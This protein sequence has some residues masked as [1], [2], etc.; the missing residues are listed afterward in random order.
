ME[1]TKSG[2]ASF[3]PIP[4]LDKIQVGHAGLYVDE[5]VDVDE[6]VESDNRTMIIARDIELE[7]EEG[8]RVQSTSLISCE[9]TIINYVKKLAEADNHLPNK[10]NGVWVYYLTKG[11]IDDFNRTWSETPYCLQP[12]KTK[13]EKSKEKGK[14][15]LS[16][17]E[18]NELVA[19]ID[20]L[21]YE[22]DISS[23]KITFEEAQKLAKEAYETK[24]ELENAGYFISTN[25]TEGV[26]LFDWKKEITETS[27][28]VDAY[29]LYRKYHIEPVIPNIASN[30]FSIEVKPKKLQNE[31]KKSIF[32]NANDLGTNP[33][34][35]D[36]L[37]SIKKYSDDIAEI[38]TIKGIHLVKIKQPGMMKP[39]YVCVET[40]NQQGEQVL[41]LFGANENYKFSA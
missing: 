30:Y 13:I 40:S 34:I 21:Y 29:K 2:V 4:D 11:L 22:K 15:V 25:K 7:E 27:G 26:S 32:T 35:F 6:A 1:T 19:K 31:V 41:Y 8:Q 9:A 3:I 38:K 14:R 18:K 20:L 5:A 36:F 28:N 12:K 37:K 24:Q 39:R 23:G 10:I 16:K 17:K 33:A